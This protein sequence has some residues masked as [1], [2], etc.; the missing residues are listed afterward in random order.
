MNR[1]GMVW[2]A[3]VVLSAL[4][5]GLWMLPARDV[6]AQAP[7]AGGKK[8][9]G[10]RAGQEWD[11]NGLK[12][13]FCWCPAGKLTMGSPG[14]EKDRDEDEDQF[15]VTISR[16][17]WL[18]KYEL[19]QREWEPV[20]GT[21]LREQRDKADK[22][23]PLYG[24]GGSHPM[25]YVSHDEATEFCR[26]LTEEERRAGKLPAGWTYTLPTEAQWEFA[27]R[28]G[29][30]A[31]FSFGDN[32]ADLEKYAWYDKNSGNAPHEVGGKRANALGAPR[33][34]RQRHGVVPRLV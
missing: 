25:Y 9:A 21:S 24:E 1:R 29:E 3:G 13:K 31:R 17:F 6:P 30:T 7:A 32:E 2:I 5:I 10:T 28:A 8:F 26:K 11:G 27:C 16:G 22:S 15:S 12:M 19:T 18:G 23:Y 14:G 20:M 34:A 33:Y 4:C